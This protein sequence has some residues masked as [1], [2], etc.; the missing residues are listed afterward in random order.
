MLLPTPPFKER[1]SSTY[2]RYPHVSA[3]LPERAAKKAER[4]AAASTKRRRKYFAASSASKEH[5]AS[6]GGAYMT[7]IKPAIEAGGGAGL[8]ALSSRTFGELLLDK[9]REVASNKAAA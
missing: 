4:R 7:L 6:G 3:T 1:F 8:A 2:F 5:R 9:W